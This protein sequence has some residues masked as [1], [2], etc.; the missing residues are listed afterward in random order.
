MSD[1]V[2]VAGIRQ[3]DSETV[4]MSHAPPLPVAAHVVFA[5]WVLALVLSSALVPGRY[6]AMLQE[7]RFIEWWTVPL[8]GAAGFF[9]LRGA[10]RDRRVFD[11]LVGAFCIFV[12][13]EEFSWGQRLL[14]FTPPAPFLEHNFQQE[15]TLHNFADI[16]GQPKW[17]LVLAL[18]GFGLL[19]P[20]VHRLPSGNRLLERIGATVPSA[21]AA[22][23]FAVAI[24]LLVWYPLSF[25]GEWVEALAGGLFLAVLAPTPRRAAIAAAAGAV[26]AI[27]LTA[28]S[29]R[30]NASAEEMACARAE[31]EALVEDL[32]YGTAATLRLAGASA[33]HK[34]VF[35]S[36]REGYIDAAGL[37][38]YTAVSCQ[39]DASAAE[40]RRHIVDP[41]GTAYW[42]HVDRG[43][44]SIAVRVYSFGPNRRR[45]GTAATGAGDD[46]GVSVRLPTAF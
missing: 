39:A 4:T 44:D 2:P 45:D 11:A 8:F 17:V 40:R 46:I 41:W 34:R 1:G 14:G 7:D 15:L 30:G 16:F 27:A 21:T 25:T 6:E 20:L 22:P 38:E 35:T 3:P 12:A 23:W 13:G 37:A 29:A 18:A 42:V 19:L 43:A 26:L 5:V 10:W 36:V 9:A 32:A 31:V 33:V 28:W 24:I